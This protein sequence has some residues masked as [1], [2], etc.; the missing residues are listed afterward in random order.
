MEPGDGGNR[1]AG[2][3]GLLDQP[4][5]FLGSA[6]PAALPAGGDF[7]TLDEEST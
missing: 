6:A 2:L 5:L 3:H 7:D 4:D 1:H